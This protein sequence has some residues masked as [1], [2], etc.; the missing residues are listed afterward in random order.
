MIMGGIVQSQAIFGL[1]MEHQL[2]RGEIGVSAIGGCHPV[3]DSKT[4]L[5]K[6]ERLTI[7]T[8]GC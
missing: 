8:I 5:Q 2:K 4:H 6:L 3:V 1:R 7:T